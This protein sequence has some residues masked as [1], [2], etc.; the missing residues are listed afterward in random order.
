MILW[1]YSYIIIYIYII[2]V[3]NGEKNQRIT[4]KWWICIDLYIKLYGHSEDYPRLSWNPST[5]FLET[6]AFNL[7]GIL[8]ALTW[9]H[10]TFLKISDQVTACD[11]TNSAPW[12]R[13]SAYTQTQNGIVESN[14]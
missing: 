11:W 2:Y 3:Y 5:K 10:I 7:D 9:V 8:I 6:D 4:N 12:L 14:N 1:G 13:Y